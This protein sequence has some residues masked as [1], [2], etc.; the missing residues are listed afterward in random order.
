MSSSFEQ[1]GSLGEWPEFYR[2]WV[3]AMEGD[4][5]NIVLKNGWA[6]E[7]AIEEIKNAWLELAD[8]KTGFAASPWGEAVAGK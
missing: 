6:D 7:K 8:K 2:G 4:V 3:N 1:P 5:G